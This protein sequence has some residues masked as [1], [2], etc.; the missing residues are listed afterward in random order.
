MAHFTDRDFNTI[1]NYLEYLEGA[2][3]KL[4]THIDPEI[5]RSFNYDENIMAVYRLKRQTE[6]DY[7]KGLFN[8]GNDESNKSKEID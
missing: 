2:Y 6:T 7:N 5:R 3:Y 1:M 8:G 4:R